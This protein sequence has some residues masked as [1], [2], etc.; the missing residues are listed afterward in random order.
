M[1]EK[2]K[3]DE[4]GYLIIESLMA[5]LLGATIAITFVFSSSS[6]ITKSTLLRQELL[7]RAIAEE[8]MNLLIENPPTFSERLTLTPEEETI[9]YKED[10]GDTKYN[11]SYKMR[12]TY[13]RFELPSLDEIQGKDEKDS[14]D[15]DQFSGKI[16]ENIQK[17]LKELIW[18]VQIEVWDP[19]NPDSRYALS[20]LLYNEKAQVKIDAF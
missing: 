13:K 2:L 18:Q 15:N 6:N 14:D 20:T 9:E 1:A 3:A 10:E 11:K 5:L 7:I 4:S 8:R 16:M 19:E 12:T 17:N